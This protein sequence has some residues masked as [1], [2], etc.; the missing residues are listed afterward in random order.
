MSKE[1]VSR[2][3]HRKFK[4]KV[5]ENRVPKL[6]SKRQSDANSF[7]KG[8]AVIS[9]HT[10]R[11]I[12]RPVRRKERK[13]QEKKRKRHCKGEREERRAREREREREKERE[14]TRAFVGTIHTGP[15]H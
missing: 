14:R 12:S 7:I 15:R 2:S 6:Q 4:T 5:F 9:T 11:P 10:F 13:R 8:I 1:I 3:S